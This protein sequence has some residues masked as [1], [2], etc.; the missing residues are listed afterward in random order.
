MVG[1]VRWQVNE[2]SEVGCISNDHC[3]N[4]AITLIDPDR[5]NFL[6]ECNRLITTVTLAGLS[7]GSIDCFPEANLPLPIGT[8]FFDI[9]PPAN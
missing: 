6:N 9:P 2:S 8:P 3:R 1:G 5:P 7:F 4:I